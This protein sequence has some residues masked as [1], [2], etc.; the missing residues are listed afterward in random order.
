MITAV[1]CAL[2]ETPTGGAGA[3]K[4]TVSDSAGGKLQGAMVEVVD[5]SATLTN[6]GGKY[7]IQNVAAGVQTVIA[8]KLGYLSQQQN[9]NVTAG[10]SV[11]VNFTLVPQ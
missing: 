7:T 11:T 3:I 6:K 8:S 2:N 4:G 10:G 9:V 1:D 5:G